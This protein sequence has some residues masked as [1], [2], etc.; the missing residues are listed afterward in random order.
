[1]S[2]ADSARRVMRLEHLRSYRPR[3]ASPCLA[4]CEAVARA[5]AKAPAQIPE[6]RDPDEA[7]GLFGK[8]TASQEYCETTYW[9]PIAHTGLAC[10][11][12]DVVVMRQVEAAR[13]QHA[14]SLLQ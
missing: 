9:L 8:L 14:P 11:S 1:M 3:I 7:I 6:Q 2:I 10:R 12:V 13:P 5:V 4:A